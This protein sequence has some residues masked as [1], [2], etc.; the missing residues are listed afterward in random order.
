MEWVWRNCLKCV[1]QGARHRPR[2]Q[3]RQA[4]GQVSGRGHT[5]EHLGRGQWDGRDG[6]PASSRGTIAGEAMRNSAPPAGRSNSQ[7]GRFGTCAPCRAWAVALLRPPASESCAPR[8]RWLPTAT[9]VLHI[10][11]GD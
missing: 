3:L 1:W 9:Q 11:P 2:H 10:H 4:H 6:A 8:A 7:P 5:N